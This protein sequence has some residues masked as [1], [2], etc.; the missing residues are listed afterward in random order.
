MF[1]SN[2]NSM[3]KLIK[4]SVIACG[5]LYLFFGIFHLTFFMTF[6]PSNP[7]FASINPF[8]SKIMFMLNVGVVVFFFALGVIILINRK[9]ILDTDI[10]RA[11]LIM[12]VLFFL[13][14]G[15]AEFLF[16]APKP[17]F[18]ISMLLVATVFAVPIFIKRK[19]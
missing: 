17:P 7:D 19:N 12:S 4:P 10:G 13:I 14:R 1:N 15:A 8:L 9:S 6:T 16:P 5:I 3:E 2:S 18:L 11:I